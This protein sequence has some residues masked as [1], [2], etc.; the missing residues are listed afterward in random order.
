MEDA[1]TIPY[2]ISQWLPFGFPPRKAQAVTGEPVEG[3]PQG[4]SL[5]LYANLNSQKHRLRA[6]LC[7]SLAAEASVLG[8][9]SSVVL[10]PT[11]TSVTAAA[12]ACLASVFCLVPTGDSAGFTARFYF[13]IVHGCIPVYVDLWQRNMTFEDLALPF[14]SLIDW[15]RVLIYRN[16]AHRQNLLAELKALPHREVKSRLEYIESIAHW[17]VTDVPNIADVDAPAALIREL[18]GRLL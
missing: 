7:A 6:R 12:A 4:K 8:L 5:L 1:L 14:P 18:E 15:R 9:N 17:L 11:M 10:R 13:S 3:L 16:Y 2:R